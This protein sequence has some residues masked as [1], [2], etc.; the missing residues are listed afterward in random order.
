[1]TVT[2]RGACVVPAVSIWTSGGA[3]ERVAPMKM[4]TVAMTPKTMTTATGAREIGCC[5]TAAG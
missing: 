1:M 2:G 3:V 5:C 4:S